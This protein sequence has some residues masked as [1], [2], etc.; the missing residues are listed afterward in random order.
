MGDSL[1]LVMR[2]IVGPLLQSGNQFHCSPGKLA[3]GIISSASPQGNTMKPIGFSSPL[4]VLAGVMLVTALPSAMP[5]P[6]ADAEAY[7]EPV[8]VPHYLPPA[9]VTKHAMVS[10]AHPLAARTGVDIL[11][12]GGN[13]IDATVA[14]QMVLN[15]VEPQSSGIGGGCFILYHDAKTKRTHCI[16]GREETPAQA[17]RADFLDANGKVID[18]ELT[19]GL[20][21]GVPGTVAAMWQAHQR[22]GNLPWVRVFEPAIK[23]ADEG[24]GVTPRLRIS[25]AANRSRFLRLPTSKAVFLH[26]DGSLPE[27]GEVLEQRDLARTLRLIADQG[28]RVFYQG[29]IAQDIVKTVQG[30]TSRAGRLTL[31]DLKHYR[32]VPREPIRFTYRGHEIV[33]MPPPSSGGITLGL[34]LGILEDS[35]I[36]ATKPGSRAEIEA[37]GPAAARVHSPIETPILAIRTGVPRSTCAAY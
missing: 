18:D 19:G 12:Q 16:D 32:A 9:T 6:P 25:I 3:T 13:A 30:S 37:A 10:A 28:P 4:A 8:E 1:Y 23:L 36:T 22:W 26:E 24:I 33:S 27:L 17:R 35:D 7:P 29:E 20:P 14:V 21:V 5:Q 11:R 2:R 34:Y 15:V 31:D